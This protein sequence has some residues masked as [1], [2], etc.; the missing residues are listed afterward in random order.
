MSL[1]DNEENIMNGWGPNDPVFET[2]KPTKQQLMMLLTGRD[3]NSNW[4]LN[5]NLKNSVLIA[6]S[7]FLKA[8]ERL[9]RESSTALNINVNMT[10]FTNLIT[11]DAAQKIAN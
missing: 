8:D 9:S 10:L 6:M 7:L 2:N 3:L 4:L 5:A 1:I 11:I